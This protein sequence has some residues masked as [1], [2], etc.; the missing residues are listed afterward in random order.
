M[1]KTKELL[2][3]LIQTI[4]TNKGGRYY[5]MSYNYDKEKWDYSKIGDDEDDMVR[6]ASIYIRK[7]D[8]VD[9]IEDMKSEIIL[10]GNQYN[11]TIIKNGTD[12]YTVG[13]YDNIYSK[14]LCK[15]DGDLEKSLIETKKYLET[16]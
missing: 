16:C 14:W 3:N 6:Q 10:G 13:Y 8:T 15:Y 1:N 2:K 11:L 7:N 12:N 9:L 4:F 5:I